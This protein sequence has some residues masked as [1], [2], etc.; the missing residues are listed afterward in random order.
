MIARAPLLALFLAAACGSGG[1]FPDAPGPPDAALP[2]TFRMDWTIKT[3]GGQMT[4]CTTA[5]ATLV[6]VNLHEEAG[7]GSFGAQFGCSLASG[8]SGPVTPGTYD[9]MFTLAGGSGAVAMA[10]PQTGIIILG[11]KTTQIAPVVFTLP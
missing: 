2:G 1:G 9:L 6:V 5:M 10:P 11:Q 4:D 3:S 8:V 7:G